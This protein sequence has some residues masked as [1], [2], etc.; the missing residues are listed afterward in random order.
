VTRRRRRCPAHRGAGASRLSHG[1]DRRRPR[2]PHPA[3]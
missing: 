3:L 1:A 2:R